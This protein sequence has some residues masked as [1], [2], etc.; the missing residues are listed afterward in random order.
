MF[1]LAL[2][3]TVVAVVFLWRRTHDKEEDDVQRPVYTV[4][5][6][7]TADDAVALV[8]TLDRG[9]GTDALAT[10]LARVYDLFP[11]DEGTMRRLSLLQQWHAREGGLRDYCTTLLYA[12]ATD[13]CARHQDR[14]ERVVTGRRSHSW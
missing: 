9:D 5:D 1:V 12:I 8:R 4:L 3:P 14:L 2:I 10:R 6:V 13:A 7:R 11:P